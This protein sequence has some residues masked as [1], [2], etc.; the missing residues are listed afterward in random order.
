MRSHGFKGTGLEYKRETDDYLIAI[1]ID[2]S[3]WGSSCSAGFAIHPKLIDQNQNGEKD[4]TKLKTNQ[5]EFKFGLTPFARDKYWEYSDDEFANLMTLSKIVE[6]IKAIAFPVIDKFIEI[7][8][9]LDQFDVY[10]MNDFHNNM[11]K[12][13]GTSISTTDL[14]FAWAMAIIFENKNLEKAIRF[15]KWAL[16][17]PDNRNS[18]WFGNKDFHRVLAKNNGA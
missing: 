3:R 15:A 18:D 10:E 16:S 9:F 1:Y 4:L 6:A 7:P 12:R 8:I 11:T 14:R 17:Q 2:P 5:Y 13:L